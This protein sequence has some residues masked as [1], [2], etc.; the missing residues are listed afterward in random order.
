MFDICD[1]HRENGTLYIRRVNSEK[2]ND[3]HTKHSFPLYM[4]RYDMHGERFPV[5][6]YCIAVLHTCHISSVYMFDI[7]FPLHMHKSSCETEY[8][9]AVDHS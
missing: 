7:T 3:V 2:V 1:V 4:Y 8:S 9:S 5:Y 6:L